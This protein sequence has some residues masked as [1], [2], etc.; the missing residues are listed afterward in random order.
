MKKYRHIFVLLLALALLGVV[1]SVKWREPWYHW[2]PLSSWLAKYGAGPGDYKPSPKAD[3][4]LRQIGS[5]A[6]PYLLKLLHSTNSHSY[7]TFVGKDYQR[8]MSPVWTPPASAV[9]GRLK[10][11]SINLRSRFQR[12]TVPASWDHWKAYLAF[13][14]LGSAGSSAIPDLVKLARDPDTNSSPSN[15]GEAPPIS[16]WKND[17]YIP[18]FAAQSSTYLSHGYPVFSVSFFGSFDGY[19]PQPFLSDGEIAAWSLAAI[20]AESVPPLMEMLTN[21][22]PQIRCRAAMALGMMGKP[23]EPAV[24][25]LANMLHDPD[26]NTR[27]ESADALGWIGQQPDFVIPALIKEFDDKDVES[28][29]IVSLGALG[30][31]ATNAIPALL[32][33]FQ[34]EYNSLDQTRGQYRIENIALAL[35]KISPDTTRKEV[36]PFLINRIQNPESPWSKSMTLDVLCQMTN[37]PDLVIPTLLEALDSTDNPTRS[38]IV[39]RLGDFGSAAKS[40]VPQLVAYSTGM[41]TNLC[42]LATNTL[43]KIEPAWR[44]GH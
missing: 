33:L 44:T 14:A 23:A 3:N 7:Y 8:G 41:D 13:Q 35:N 18:E 19:V 22:N 26:R 27:R 9:G 37:Q 1:V 15:T 43:N 4:A 36:M 29:A 2:K 16:F 12:V 24:H 11:W 21:S 42:R 32:A 10:A 25:A 28:A 31:R 38:E 40:A 20:G 5:N 39:Y 17:K 6:V 30:E 34:A